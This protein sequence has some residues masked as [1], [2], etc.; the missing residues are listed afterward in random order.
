MIYFIVDKVNDHYVITN[1]NLVESSPRFQWIRK[2]KMIFSTESGAQDY[3]KKQIEERNET[4]MKRLV[5]EYDKIENK[6]DFEYLFNVE[7]S[8][9]SYLK[10]K[11]FI[12][13]LKK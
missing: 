2:N 4:K 10:L 13:Y 11:Q 6:Q 8:D 3:L 5:E 9:V 7:I 12:D 1:E